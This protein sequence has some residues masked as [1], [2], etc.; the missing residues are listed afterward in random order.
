[1]RDSVKLMGVLLEQEF[2]VAD[3]Q[4]GV[5]V[6][7]SMMMQYRLIIDPE[8]QILKYRNRAHKVCEGYPP[9]AQTR[10]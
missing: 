5:I 2:L 8:E 1:M 7:W 4:G 3:I 10:T 9:R 6:G